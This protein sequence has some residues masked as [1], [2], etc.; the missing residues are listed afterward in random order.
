MSKDP[1]EIDERTIARKYG[2][3]ELVYPDSEQVKT[4]SAFLADAVEHGKCGPVPKMAVM[5]MHDFLQ[6]TLNRQNIT[7]GPRM[8][9]AEF[10]IL[11]APY[12]LATRIVSKI[13]REKKE[14]AEQKGKLYQTTYLTLNQFTELLRN[15][16]DPGC[17]WLRR[18]V[19]E[20]IREVMEVLWDFALAYPEQRRKGRAL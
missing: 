7:K 6:G 13:F 14:H 2:M 11:L 17:Y 4:L 16:Q 3:R 10:D 1:E 15:V 8:S 18:G 5:V 19:P 20:G 9:Q 12:Y